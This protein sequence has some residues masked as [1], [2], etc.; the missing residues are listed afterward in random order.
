MLI[1]KK[2]TWMAFGGAVV[3]MHLAA[4]F[5]AVDLFLSCRV[6][7]EEKT[8]AST[9][10]EKAET[11]SCLGCHGPFGKL[12]ERTS[13]YVTEQGEKANP[14][15]YVPHDSTNIPACDNFHGVHPLPVTPPSNI[16]KSNVQ[17]C[18]SAC[19]HENDFAP[20]VECHKDRK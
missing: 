1:G 19:H 2:A 12:A 3:A 16:A 9:S 8:A 15:V 20:C 11:E 10:S 14:H 18:Y 13:G 7:A 17:Y 4:N 6:A 5:L